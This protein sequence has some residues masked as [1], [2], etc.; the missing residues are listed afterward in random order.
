MEKQEVA[1]VYVT[2]D[3][4]AFKFFKENRKLNPR[5]YAKLMASMEE[6]QLMI[7]II[8]N[9]KMEIVDGQHRYSAARELGLPI[10]YFVNEGYGIEEMKRSNMVGET[11]TLEDFLHLQIESN[12]P[13]YKE[14]LDLKEQYSVRLN[15]LLKIF[16]QVQGKNLK[17]MQKNFEM[18]TITLEGKDK[19]IEFL[20]ALQDFDF[21]PIYHTRNFFC[22]FMRLYFQQNYD[23]E[24]MRERLKVRKG[25]VEYKGTSDEY[26]VM[27]TKEIYSFGAIKKPLYYDKETKKFY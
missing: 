12:V 15:D 9:E 17:I 11:W 22:A 24:R 21:F 7:P 16:A 25:V 13:Q 10:Y 3:Y 4:D 20:E 27:L 18:G 5:N 19:V 14:L 6:E 1:K 26:L 8:V 2:E 23:H